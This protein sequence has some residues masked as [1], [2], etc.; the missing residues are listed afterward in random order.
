MENN[1][2]LNKNIH[3]DDKGDEIKENMNSYRSSKSHSFYAGVCDFYIS[4][5]LFAGVIAI[6]ESI[7]NRTFL[8]TEV[9][10]RLVF[11]LISTALIIT[12]VI[13]YHSII[14]KKV[15]WLS[16]GEKI[17]GKFIINNKKEWVNPYNVNRWGLFCHCI[18][19]L[20]ILG[21][22]FNAI[23]SVY[24][25]PIPALIGKFIRLFIQFYSLVMIGQGKLKAL[26]VFMGLNTISILVGLLLKMPSFFITFFV[27]LLLLDIIVYCTYY[28][29]SKRVVKRIEL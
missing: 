20:I 27:F 24:Q 17:A 13:I 7:I 8:A 10:N 19:T 21:N 5:T 3:V 22:S 28:Q 12:L 16:Y 1:K 11:F 9:V 25:Y 2:T 26:L 14:S 4:A 23:S 6:I 18:I 29:L 15:L